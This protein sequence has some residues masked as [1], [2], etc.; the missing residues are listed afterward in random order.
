MFADA[1][2]FAPVTNDAGNNP[3]ERDGAIS[4]SAAE[5]LNPS[6]FSWSGVANFFKGAVDWVIG[7]N[8]GAAWGSLFTEKWVPGPTGGMMPE[9]L[10]NGMLDDADSLPPD[11]PANGMHAWH[12]GSNAY[13]AQQFGIIGA[14]LLFLGGLYHESPL[15]WESFK[16][17]QRDQGTVNH[18]L[19][20][21]MDIVANVFGMTVGYLVPGKSGVDLAT[22]WGNY[23]PGPGDP[24]PLG[25]GGGTP[26]KGNPADAWGH[27]PK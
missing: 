23:I 14:P 17:E 4:S 10:R 9:S 19:D 27:Y 15:D 18:I 12:A 24:N 26:Y 16:A 22:R 6:K 11:A 20:S 2:K 21:G 1:G 7:E 5:M 3:A 8:Y 25:K 13:L